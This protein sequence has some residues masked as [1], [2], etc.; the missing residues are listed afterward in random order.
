MSLS[1][2]RSRILCIRL[3]DEEYEGL[4]ILCV[5]R[6]ERSVSDA[7]R[8]AMRQMLQPQAASAETIQQMSGR[9]QELDG[10]LATLDREVNRLYNLFAAKLAQTA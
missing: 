5:T 2:N 6:G 10:R 7:A 9:L 8:H 3:S 4:K 1:K